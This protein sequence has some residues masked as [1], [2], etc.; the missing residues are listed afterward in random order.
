MDNGKCG[1]QPCWFMRKDKRTLIQ[2]PDLI[3]SCK[4]ARQ[5]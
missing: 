2:Q 5:I 3:K 1:V 4:G